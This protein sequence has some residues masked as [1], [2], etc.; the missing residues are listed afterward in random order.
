MG[1]K[2]WLGG[3]FARSKDRR[4]QAGAAERR[5]EAAALVK[6]LEVLRLAEGPVRRAWQGLVLAAQ[7]YLGAAAQARSYSPTAHEAL[8]AA[9]D[10]IAL[11]QKEADATAVERR[12]GLDDAD[13][14]ESPEDRVAK[15]LNRR[16]AILREQT[17]ALGG[18]VPGS[19]RL[20]IEE[21]LG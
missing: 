4:W 15:A 11:W 19:T 14:L 1:L 20:H 5:Q 8:E 10:L 7:A 3:L 12:F 9:R 2:T 13:P 17:L 6:R 21:E 16:T 18:G